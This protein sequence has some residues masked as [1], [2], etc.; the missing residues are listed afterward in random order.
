MIKDDCR[1]CDGYFHVCKYTCMHV[2]FIEGRVHIIICST[3]NSCSL[4]NIVSNIV[5]FK[6]GVFC[7][8]KYFRYQLFFV[9]NRQVMRLGRLTT[10]LFQILGTNVM[11]G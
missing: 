2:V 9:Q 6:D 4:E 8:T 10:Q 1:I 11:F 7:H 3:E 5:Q